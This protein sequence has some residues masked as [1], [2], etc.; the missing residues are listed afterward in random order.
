M[1]YLDYI[2]VGSYMVGLIYMGWLVSGES[3]KESYFLGGRSFGWAPLTLSTM[4]T[5]LSAISFISAP[6]FVGL[7]EGGGMAWLGFEFGVPLAMLVLMTTIIPAL[8]KSGVVS[9]FEFLERRFGVSTRILLSIVFQISRA[10][11]TGIMVYILAI[12]L[13]SVLDISYLQTI[14][15]IGVVTIVYSTE[16]G[17]KAVVWGDVVQMIMITVGLMICVGFGLHHLGGWD[18]FTA[19]VDRSRLMAVDYSSFGFSGDEFGF[20]PLVFGGMFLYMSYYGCDQTQ[21]QRA[22]SAKSEHTLRQMLL[23]NGVL[24]FPITLL[25]CFLGL[26]IGTFALVTPEYMASIPANEPDKMMP[27]FIRDYLPNGIKGILIIAIFSA[28]MSSLSSTINSLTAVSME[29]LVSRGYPNLSDKAYGWVSKLV[30]VLWGGIILIFSLF[31]GDIAD[32]IIEAINKVGSVFYGPILALFVIAVFVRNVNVV[33]ANIGLLSGVFLNM[34]FWLAQ[35]QIFWLW[36]NLI[37][38]VVTVTVGIIVSRFAYQ[39]HVHGQENMLTFS[40][41]LLKSKFA[42]ILVLYFVGIVLFATALPSLFN[43][44]A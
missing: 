37:G 2:I 27:I 3:D 16:G 36:W 21:V 29:D 9:I 6:A 25:Y 33:G 19:N 30:C 7:R 14:A 12:I 23:A 32:T 22:M 44:I 38:F 35:P 41:D 4:A 42:L 24:R 10:F 28:A 39:G 40:F 26:I 5:Q 18:V 17:M 13:E 20:W 31:A 34:Y 8:Y 43:L 15:I 1:N 11:A